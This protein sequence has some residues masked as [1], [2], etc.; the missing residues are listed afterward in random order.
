MLHLD[1]NKQQ[2]RKKQK[3]CLFFSCCTLEHKN[4]QNKKSGTNYTHIL[5]V[6]CNRFLQYTHIQ[7]KLTQ[8]TL[9]SNNKK[10]K[11]TEQNKKKKKKKLFRCCFW[12]LNHTRKKNKLKSKINQN[13]GIHHYDKLKSSD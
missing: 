7:A 13:N 8:S 5:S 6:L 2:Q 11:R 9:A 3:A 10:K 1:V 4:K 12:F